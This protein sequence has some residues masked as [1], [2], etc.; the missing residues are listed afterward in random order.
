MNLLAQWA[1]YFVAQASAAAALTGLI[2]VALS[3]NLDHVIEDGAWLGRAATGLIMLAQPI[4]YALVCLLPLSTASAQGWVLAGLG[5]VASGAVGRIVLSRS[6]RLASR[7][8]AEL[9][10]RAVVALT[11]SVTSV[12][13]AILVVAGYVAGVFVLAV[14]AIVGLGIGLVTAWALLVEVRRSGRQPQ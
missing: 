5:V 13:G 12:V 11:E 2:F 10:V 8:P 14:G 3:L 6:S 7:T 4:V 1:N 9:A